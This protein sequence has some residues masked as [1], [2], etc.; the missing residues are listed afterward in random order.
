MALI[1][2][3]L[4]I[5]RSYDF[6]NNKILNA[7][8]NTPTDDEHIVNKK[9]TDDSHIYTT[10]KSTEYNSSF[11]H[12]WLL[13][14]NGKTYKQIFDDL[15]FPRVLPPFKNP[16]LISAI[17]IF[18]NSD[19]VPHHFLKS[20]FLLFKKHRVS[21]KL[22]C[23]L[24]NNDRLP[25]LN[26]NV[27]LEIEYISGAIE[28]FYSQS[29]DDFNMIDFEYTVTDETIFRLKREYYPA[30]SKPDSY[31]DE[32]LPAEFAGNYSFNTNISENVYDKYIGFDSPLISVAKSS[33]GPV[34]YTLIDIAYEFQPMSE[35]LLPNDTEGIYDILLPKNIIDSDANKYPINIDIFKEI[36]NNFQ[37]VNSTLL[38]FDW[39][40]YYYTLEDTILHDGIEYYKCQYNF[41]IYDEP[42]KIK[43]N[44][45]RV[46]NSTYF[47]SI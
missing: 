20:L 4:K 15:F 28:T 36:N 27:Y 42:I 35:I 46:L 29:S 6:R 45:N 30:E 3:I 16:E 21:G 22:F 32:Y 1:G 11:K 23:T 13:N 25:Q 43:F 44:F 5:F 26:S 19:I 12:W 17:V 34:D 47:K 7:K 38:Q 40:T 9:Y 2:E 39:L 18:D 31:G 41:G 10:T 24:K 37:L 8:T 14:I 33:E